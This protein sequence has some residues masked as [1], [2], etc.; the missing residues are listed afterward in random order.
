MSSELAPS[1][2]I[3]EKE[4]ASVLPDSPPAQGP[5]RRMGSI[6]AYRGLVMFLMMAEVLRFCA[7][8]RGGAGAAAIWE[9][10]CH[11]QSHVEWIGCSLH[12][13]IQPSFSFLVGVAL[14]VLAGQPAGPGA[15][16]GADDGPRRLAV[17]RARLPGRLPP[18]GRP[19]PDQ[20]HLRGHAL[21]DRPGLHVP[22]PA[23][24]TARSATS[25][26]PSSLIAGRLLGAVRG[27]SRCPGPDF[28]YSDGRRAGG[29]A[30]TS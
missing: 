3:K 10:L 4:V 18:L 5:P 26:S 15:V 6:D 9:F 8:A 19:R 25:G 30:S 2:S 17:A 16:E 12:D 28:E 11:H 23:G 29:L 20:L 24:L 13:M 27:L 7:V 22:V 14:A 1:P 21:A